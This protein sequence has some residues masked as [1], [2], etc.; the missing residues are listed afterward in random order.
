MSKFLGLKI[1]IPAILVMA[2]MLLSAGESSATHVRYNLWGTLN[3]G[4][5]LV[6]Y[7]TYRW[8]NSGSAAMEIWNNTGAGGLRYSR[9]GLRNLADVQITHTNQ[10]NGDPGGYI[11]FRRASNNSLTIPTAYYALNG[12]M[13]NCFL[14]DNYWEGRLELH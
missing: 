11:P 8:H 4:G 9:F 1:A 6:Q 14:C 12:R 10:Y 2:F 13:A 3:T 5:Y 7:S